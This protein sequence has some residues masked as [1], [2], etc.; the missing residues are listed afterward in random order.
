M[1][2]T[3]PRGIR[4]N[5][6]GNLRPLRKDVWQGEVTPD[7]GEMGSYSVFV[8]PE[9][10]IR[11]MIRDVRNKRRRGLD[12]IFKILSAYAPAED[13]NN[14]EAYSHGVCARVGAMLQI[15]LE[16]HD[17]LPPDTI[18]FRIAMAKAQV[19]VENGS[20]GPYGRS[21]YWYNDAM[22]ARGAEL[23]ETK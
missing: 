7:T 19:R 21:D 2:K 12:T 16:P 5:N 11:A 1:E 9:W 8:A 13:N 4:N 10:G 18:P 20:G 22:Y 17:P 6:P 23:E 14:V 15:Q 3:L